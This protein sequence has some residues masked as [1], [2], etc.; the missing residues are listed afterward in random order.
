MMSASSFLL[1]FVQTPNLFFVSPLFAKERRREKKTSFSSQIFRGTHFIQIA[2][3]Q[4][5]RDFCNC[6]CE[7]NKVQRVKSL[8]NCNKNDWIATRISIRLSFNPASEIA[9][10]TTRLSLKP[11]SEICNNN[12]WI[13]LETCLW[14]FA[15]KRTIDFS[16]KPDSENL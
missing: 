14:N 7:N 3:N 9:I 12:Y 16:L 15:I 5:K 6:N 11:A 13:R 8:W 1:V 10:R 2:S 4:L